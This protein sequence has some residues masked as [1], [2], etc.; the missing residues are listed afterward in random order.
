MMRLLLALCFL[1][2]QFC[3]APPAHA[4]TTTTCLHGETGTCRLATCGTD[5]QNAIDASS[6]G[7]SGYISPTSF[8]GDGVYIQNCSATSMSLSWSDK[9]INLRGQNDCTLDGNN[10]PTACGTNMN[11]SFTITVSDAGGRKAAFAISHIAVNSATLIN[12]SNGNPH[13]TQAIAGY[14]RVHHLLFNRSSGS[15]SLQHYG[16]VYGLY[17]HLRVNMTTDSQ[18]PFLEQS[19]YLNN[20]YNVAPTKFMGEW[21]ALK[22]TPRGT[23]N[24]V[25]IEDSFFNITATSGLCPLS[26]S[27]S[28]PGHLVFRYNTVTSAGCYVYFYAHWTRNNEW[29]GSWREFYRNTMTCS[30]GCGGGWPFRLESGTGVIYDNQ[31]SGWGDN[32][33]KV[34]EGRGCGG[35][36]GLQMGQCDG[37]KAWDM[38]AGDTNA[39][40]WPCASQIG[41]GCLV[42]GGCSRGDQ[43]NVPLILW[44][45][46]SQSGCATGGSCTNSLSV[47]VLNQ[48]GEATETCTRATSN[49]IKSTAHTASG[50]FN[51]AVDYCD[52]LSSKP[53]T[54]G[55][56]TNNYTAYTYPH[57]LQDSGSAPSAPSNFRFVLASLLAGIAA[58]FG[59]RAA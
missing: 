12:Y 58:F 52:G 24:N 51:N 32:T 30:G 55:T 23:I 54:C 39:P 38:N 41:V 46:G 56:Y 44:N 26:D 20:E 48:H 22:E 1:V 17:D 42:S 25:Y 57:P 4:Y 43:D 3:V 10:R 6:A 2:A 31:I 18:N 45:N 35:S 16:V 37:S 50:K 14:F 28:G 27:E 5:T 40:G 34:D 59:L 15:N 29:D 8:D 36:T 49:Y 47:F 33:V 7:G 21:S 13:S 19:E 11:G 9:N 53:S